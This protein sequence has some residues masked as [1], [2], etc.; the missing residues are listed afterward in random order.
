VLVLAPNLETL[1]S[2]LY[3]FD[4]LTGGLRWQ[5]GLPTLLSGGDDVYVDGSVLYWVGQSN[6]ALR[7]FD[8][9]SL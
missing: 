5:R 6:A 4:A 3:C 8:S 2:D 1:H 7:S 9:N